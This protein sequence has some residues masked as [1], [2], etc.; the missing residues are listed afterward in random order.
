MIRSFTSWTEAAKTDELRGHWVAL[1]NCRYD[2]V[3]NQPVEGDIVD[4]DEDLAELC[5]RLQ[6]SSKSKCTI[7]YF[8]A[9]TIIEPTRA[10]SHVEYEQRRSA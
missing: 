3:S 2:R 10:S 5:A 1:D 6:R 8:D 9:D 7:L 4:S